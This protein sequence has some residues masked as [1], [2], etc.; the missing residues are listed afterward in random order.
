MSWFECLFYFHFQQL[1]KQSTWEAGLH[2]NASHIEKRHRGWHNQ[3]DC[4]MDCVGT[5][6]TSFHI[7]W[8]LRLTCSRR[9]LQVLHICCFAAWLLTKHPSRVPPIPYKYK[10]TLICPWESDYTNTG[11]RFTGWQIK[12]VIHQAIES[13][14]H[15]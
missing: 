1:I 11:V 13:I 12:Q 4:Q 14:A 2:W 9:A 6:L 10:H 3:M 7:S 5:S 15:I 8:C